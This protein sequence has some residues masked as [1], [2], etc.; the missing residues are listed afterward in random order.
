ARRLGLIGVA[1]ITLL[2]VGA[3]DAEADR[4]ATG[5]RAPRWVVRAAEDVSATR[6]G[7]AAREEAVAAKQSAAPTAS[8]TAGA[9][10]PT[11]SASRRPSAW[12]TASATRSTPPAKPACPQ[13]EKQ[14][15]V[16][17]YLA[18]L[19]GFGR[20]TIDGRQSP[21]DCAAIKKFQRR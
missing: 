21:E 19:G 13:G 1:A 12:P 5:E 20:V 9:P 16:E 8:A 11:T 10:K 18:Y 14:R 6:D 17:R 4:A 7:G 2:S 15:E 3:C